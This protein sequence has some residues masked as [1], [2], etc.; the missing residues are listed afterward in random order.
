MNLS[1]QHP[2]YFIAILPP[3]GIRKEIEGF[4]EK[5]REDH[6]IKHA[7]KLP[8]HITI[9]IPFRISKEQEQEL[10]SKLHIFSNVTH[11]FPIN[12]DGF[13]KFDKSVIFIKIKNHD[14]VIKLHSKLTEMI[15][16]FIPLKSH[17]ISSKIH[18]HVT[19][20]VRDLKRSNFQPVWED[21]EIR[22]YKNS[23][24]FDQLVL[25]KHNGKTWDSINKFSIQQ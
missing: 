9:Q 14:P 25:F 24:I 16:S 6:D 2:L 7:L 4:K 21:F 23:F 3:L 20:A 22:E 17:E 15:R 18:P 5:I 11:P 19:I 10:I 13:G 12:L 8:A 1:K